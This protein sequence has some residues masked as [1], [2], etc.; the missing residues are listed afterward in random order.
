MMEMANEGFHICS[1]TDRKQRTG[2]KRSRKEWLLHGRDM[3][4]LSKGEVSI[5]K[6]L[7]GRNGVLP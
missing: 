7:M 5:I 2:L 1:N 6:V 4:Y 3:L